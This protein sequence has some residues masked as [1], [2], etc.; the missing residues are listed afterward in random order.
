MSKTLL[1]TV[2]SRRVASLAIAALGALAATSHAA[3]LA[4][5][6][7]D[8]PAAAPRVLVERYLSADCANCWQAL[9][10][11]PAKALPGPS[12][13]IDWIVPGKLGADA[14]LAVAALPEAIER[15]A[16]AGSLRSDEALTQTSP[17]P[18]RG[19]LRLAVQDGPAMNGYIGVQMQ[20][21]N[22]S[23]APL[24]PGLVAYMAVVER[25]AAGEE[26][27][28]V[29]RQL[30]RTLLGPVPLDS[31]TAQ[32]PVIDTRAAR[33]PENAKPE[34]LTLIGWIET[35]DG[36]VLLTANAPTAACPVRAV[37][38]RRSPAA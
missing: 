23:K 37:A 13:A 5:G 27:T 29:A 14:P 20:V 1:G 18:A 21:A 25:I 33:Y 26:G 10:P 31:L 28:P 2:G 34:R 32:H 15:A 35:A 17:L 19:A 7:A 24:P 38:A 30:V 4:A 11:M 8:C 9:P 6:N 36:H 12:I 22:A 16:R 3:G